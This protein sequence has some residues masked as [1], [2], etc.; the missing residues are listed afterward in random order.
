MNKKLF[1]KFAHETDG[2]IAILAA[3]MSVALVGAAGVG[4]DTYNSQSS[5]TALRH[6]VDLTCDRLNNADIALFPTAGSVSKMAQGFA[7]NLKLGTA[8]KDADVNVSQPANPSALSG[9]VI[10]SASSTFSPTFTAV[11]GA[12][13]F[14]MNKTATCKRSTVIPEKRG[15]SAK[16]NIIVTYPDL[17]RKNNISVNDLSQYATTEDVGGGSLNYVYT[18]VDKDNNITIRKFF[19]SD[20]DINPSD[21]PNNGKDQGMYVQVMNSDGSIP[22]LEKQC[23]IDNSTPP[24]PVVTVP[25]NPPVS[26][27]SCNRADDKNATGML[28]ASG[29]M[30]G[31]I[32]TYGNWKISTFSNYTID[33]PVKNVIPGVTS[34]ITVT[35]KT[36][37]KALIVPITSNF[38]RL[39]PANKDVI[40]A[41]AEMGIDPESAF[42]IALLAPADAQP[43]FSYN[44]HAV[45]DRLE[46]GYLLDHILSSSGAAWQFPGDSSG[47]CPFTISP[48][49]IDLTNKGSIETTGISTAQ[50]AIRTSLGKAVKFDILANG[51]PKSMEWLNGSG[52]GFLVDNR[53]GNAAKDMT[54]KRLFGNDATHENGFSKLAATFKTDGNGLIY[55]DNL[56]GLAV[57]VDNGDGIVQPGEIKSLSALGITAISTRM[58]SVKDAKG[59]T[60]MRSYIIRNNAHVMSEDV[61]FGVAQ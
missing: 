32:Q 42:L 17:T 53:D 48:I 5:D 29:E 1:S 20:V 35:S 56:T 15:K 49:V 3:V 25:S 57:W 58:A 59:D 26:G 36:T 8:A 51:S 47:Y 38:S 40:Q 27:T 19:S 23:I 39:D 33:P 18:V 16:C 6:I 46:K 31:R 2:S 7:D 10:V 21:F 9:D 12:Q 60:L 4:I 11:I 54:G 55:G 52:Q 41:T 24:T 43:G 28:F 13:P 34:A 45:K 30:S 61:W 22:R 50:K 14:K 37:G 44:H